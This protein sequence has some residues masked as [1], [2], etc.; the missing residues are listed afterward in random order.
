MSISNYL[1][2][3][4]EKK[5]KLN[6]PF[7]EFFNNYFRD[8]SGNLPSNIGSRFYFTESMS[9]DEWGKF[10]KKVSAIEEKYNN[11]FTLS[12]AD[13]VID[14]SIT[15]NFG[16]GVYIV[17]S[18]KPILKLKDNRNDWRTVQSISRFRY[19]DKERRLYIKNYEFLIHSE[20]RQMIKRLVE[21]YQAYISQNEAPAINTSDKSKLISINHVLDKIDS[22]LEEL[23]AKREKILAFEVD[24]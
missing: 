14:T 17:V 2:N 11:D 5:A 1:T 9:S 22:R 15:G 8:E 6:T 10:Y 24:E 18:D 20:D 19:D 23:E 13:V 12:D 3:T 4:D 7:I 16:S 21:C